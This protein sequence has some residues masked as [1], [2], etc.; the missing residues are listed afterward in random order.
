MGPNRKLR[1]YSRRGKHSGSREEVKGTEEEGNTV[2]IK[3]KLRAY[4]RRAQM[5][6]LRA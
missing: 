2:A 6:N 3:R 1:A 5:R 4:S